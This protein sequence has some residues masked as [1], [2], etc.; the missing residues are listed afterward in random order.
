MEFSTK[1]QTQR[2]SE[3]LGEILKQKGA[4]LVTAESCTGGGIASAIT[5]IA[6]SS[7]WFDR[8]FVTYS[9]QAK[10]EMLGVTEESLTQYG[11][12]SQQVVK[13]M[14]AGALKNSPGNVAIS[15]SGIA[16]PGG[17]S[18]EKPVGTVWFGWQL[19]GGEKIQQVEC[20]AGDRAQVRAQSVQ[21]AL[22]ELLRLLAD[23]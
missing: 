13:E 3:K 11:A 16:G 17:G 6:G 1:N 5:D 23:G 10:M 4:V 8:A 2:L 12:V 21:Y 9:N 19:P 22:E 7:E 20:F 15:V 18:A 14:A